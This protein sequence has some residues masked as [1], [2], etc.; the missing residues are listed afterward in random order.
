MVV[1]NFNFDSRVQ[2]MKKILEII[3]GV[4]KRSAV[5]KGDI[6]WFQTS[7]QLWQIN[8]ELYFFYDSI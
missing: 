5:T 1:I 2:E 4:L 3:P 6:C 7:T 8:D